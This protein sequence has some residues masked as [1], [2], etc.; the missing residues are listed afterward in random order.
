MAIILEKERTQIN[1][2][3]VLI[4]FLALLVV[5]TGAYFIFFKKPE[6]IDIT[7]PK[8]FSDLD[9]ISRISFDPNEVLQSPAFKSLRQYGDKI[10]PT[11]TPGKANPFQM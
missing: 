10:T 4:I 5:F 6:F 8:R 9:M 1:W 2:I 3:T 11:Q 7:T